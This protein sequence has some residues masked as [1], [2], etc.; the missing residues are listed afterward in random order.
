[1]PI[2]IFSWICFNCNTFDFIGCNV[3]FKRG[4]D[5]AD[6]WHRQS[7]ASL[8]PVVVPQL[9]IQTAAAK[10]AAMANSK[11]LAEAA[12]AAEAAAA[13]AVAAETDMEHIENGR[14]KNLKKKIKN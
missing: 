13:A 3:C 8:H 12:S 1:M 7:A 14:K 2:N 11:W 10:A 5:A 4:H 9:N 6:C